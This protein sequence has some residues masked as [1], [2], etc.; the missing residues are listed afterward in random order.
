MSIAEKLATIA[1]N[2]QRV[3]DAGKQAEYD[4]FWDVFQNN[5]NREEY[6]YAFAYG[7][8]WTAATFRPK[9]K[10]Y[11][12]TASSM[13]REQTQLNLTE[14]AVEVD[15]SRC[16]NFNYTFMSGCPKIGV[17][18]ASAASDLN[19]TFSYY[20]VTSIE[21]LIVHEGLSFTSTFIQATYLEDI[22]IEGTIAKTISFAQSKK[23]TLESAKSIITALKDFTG[24]GKEFTT[25]VTLHADVWALLDADGATSPTGTTWREYVGEKCWNS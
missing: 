19:Q 16:T 7:G 6:Q 14:C 18:D 11:P 17:V 15:F 13:F 9:Y 8:K 23:L 12:T 21:K 2:E 22:V 20:F 1:E 5:G 24:T 25:T 10:L 3:F 4:A